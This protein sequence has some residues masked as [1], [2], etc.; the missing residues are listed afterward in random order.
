M[1]CR[2]R[3]QT[4]EEATVNYFMWEAMRFNEAHPDFLIAVHCTH[5]FN[6]TGKS[7]SFDYCPIAVADPNLFC[8]HDNR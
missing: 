3:G 1:P 5:G 4:P 8:T 6:R 7:R 2:G